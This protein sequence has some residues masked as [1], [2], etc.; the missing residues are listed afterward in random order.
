MKRKVLYV[1]FEP[2]VSGQT[3]HVLSL[4]NGLNKDKYEISVVVPAHLVEYL[5]A[6]DQTGVT[7]IPLPMRK[8]IWNIRSLAVLIN[9]IRQKR[10]HIVHVHS[11]EAGLL[12][13]LLTRIA[14]AGNIIYTPQCTNIRRN[15]LFWLYRRI[16]KLLSSLTDMIISVSEADRS[17]IV[18]WGIPSS[19]VIT[20]HNSIDPRKAA[21][22]PDVTGL[23]HK[24]NLDEKAPIVMQ[25]G[26]LSYQKNPLDFVNGAS[27][28][29]AEIPEVH[30]ILVGDGP[31]REQVESRIQ[32]LGLTKNVHCAGW[33]D[34]AFE[35]IA[36][37]DII[38]LT[39]RWEGL[40]Y[41][42]LEAMAWSRPIVATAVNGC[43]ELVDQ[44][45]TGYV[46]P[47][48]KI[49]SWAGSVVKLLNNPERAVEMGLLGNQRLKKKF[50]MEKMIGK[51]EGLYDRL[52]V[53]QPGYEV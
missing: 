17:R 11:Q 51:T 33:Q 8:Y 20:I 46:V 39:S 25:V 45:V 12:V 19:K 37:A 24:L 32:E 53:D 1:Y 9:L 10:F 50:N 29:L 2:Q 42:L 36:A 41:V 49:D 35:L 44:G 31:L 52:I 48:G 28:V 40:P 6:F 23:K 47:E 26:R 3:T 22:T 16:E 7:M 15:N 38:T 18:Q 21:A 13:R 4:V 43:P 27:I 14:G 34:D 30:F 5:P